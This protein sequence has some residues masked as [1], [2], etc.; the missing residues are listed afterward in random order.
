MEKKRISLSIPA[1]LYDRLEDIREKRQPMS[2]LIADIL[3]FH[4]DNHGNIMTRNEHMETMAR[5]DEAIQEL[6]RRI[7]DLNATVSGLT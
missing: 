6:S 3:Q 5:K 4:A 2:A 7:D 1:D